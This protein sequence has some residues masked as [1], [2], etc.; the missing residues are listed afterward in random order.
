MED[1]KTNWELAC[2]RTRTMLVVLVVTFVAFILHSMVSAFAA[3]AFENYSL[4][5]PEGAFW[6]VLFLMNVLA[7]VMRVSFVKDLAAAELDEA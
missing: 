1:L 7:I 2:L 3:M 5:L 4:M 6:G